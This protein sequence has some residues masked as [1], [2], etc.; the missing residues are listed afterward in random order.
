M[1]PAPVNPTPNPT[2]AQ[3]SA[4]D[5][6]WALKS[7]AVDNWDGI[8][9]AGPTLRKTANEIRRTNRRDGT[10]MKKPEAQEA[11][12]IA[13]DD[14]RLAPMSELYSNVLEATHAA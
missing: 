4:W 5:K 12:L 11:A 1:N 6:A 13:L 10:P 9:Y 7:A 2:P 8:E 3:A 14:A